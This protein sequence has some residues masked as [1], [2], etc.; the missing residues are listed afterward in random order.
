MPPH[1]QETAKW[2]AAWAGRTSSR[3]TTVCS[4]KPAEPPPP[5]SEIAE[6]KVRRSAGSEPYYLGSEKK[7]NNNKYPLMVKCHR[8]VNPKFGS[9][10]KLDARAASFHPPNYHPPVR[11]LLLTWPKHL[12]DQD[13]ILS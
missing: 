7:K 10:E 1:P 4:R 5:H 12:R 3:Q 6:R 9:L 11:Y 8:K 13:G 2:W